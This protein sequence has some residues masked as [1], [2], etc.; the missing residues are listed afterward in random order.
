MTADP[1][2]TYFDIPADIKE[3]WGEAQA[4]EDRGDYAAIND[5]QEESVR[6][7]RDWLARWTR[8]ATPCTTTQS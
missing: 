2:P 8:R 6:L 1:R 4:A 7:E 5:A 3:L